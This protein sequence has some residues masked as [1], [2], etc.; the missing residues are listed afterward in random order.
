MKKHAENQNTEL[1]TANE[2]DEFDID[3]E[4][5]LRSLLLPN[6]SAYMDKIIISLFVGLCW[7]TIGKQM[8]NYKYEIKNEHI[9][10]A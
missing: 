5:L 8:Y 6:K 1:I 9:K 3:P 7:N 10:P 2:K 4:F